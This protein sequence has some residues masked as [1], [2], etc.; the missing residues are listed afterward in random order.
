M[1]FLLFLAGEGAAMVYY[2]PN[3]VRW[4]RATGC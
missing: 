4:A 2:V 1:I 3:S